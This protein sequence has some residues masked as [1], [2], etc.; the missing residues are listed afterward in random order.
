MWKNIIIKEC[1]DTRK[2]LIYINNLSKRT[3]IWGT[4]LPGN[5]CSLCSSSMWKLH[6]PVNVQ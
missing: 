3:A 1:K 4:V 5:I 6:H 2:A